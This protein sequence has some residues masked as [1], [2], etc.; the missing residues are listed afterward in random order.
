MKSV[1]YLGELFPSPSNDNSHNFTQSFLLS[2]LCMHRFCAV[3]V[4]KF[5]PGPLLKIIQS[6]VFESLNNENIE[7][8]VIIWC[9]D[10]K[11][12][13]ALMR[14]GHISYWDVHKVTNMAGL[15]LL[16]SKFNDNI[17]LWDVSNVTDMSAMFDLASSFNQPLNRWNVSNVK[18]MCMMFCCTKQFN[19]PLDAWDV[20]NVKDM[21]GM[22]YYSSFNQPLTSWNLSNCQY[23]RVCHLIH[24]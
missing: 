20:K 11:K 23:V 14:F 21:K 8:A 19:Q 15:F 22:F 24:E 5:L 16:K 13:E 4:N 9:K 2:E 7:E 3:H 10:G 1:E 12:N 17:E 6:Y 18:D